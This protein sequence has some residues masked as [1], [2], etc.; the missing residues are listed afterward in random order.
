MSLVHAAHDVMIW[1]YHINQPLL[2]LQIRATSTVTT[3]M[4][5]VGHVIIIVTSS[6]VGSS[7]RAARATC[8]T[9]TG[10]H[11]E[12]NES[13][14]VVVTRCTVVFTNKIT[15]S[16]TSVNNLKHYFADINECLSNNGGCAQVCVNTPGSYRCSCD[17]GFTLGMDGKLC[18]GT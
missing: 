6:R 12:V 7:V 18:Y 5:L 8:C 9:R 15:Y 4:A 16:R 3:V 17:P 2:C 11:A 13:S 1:P 14:Q 10:D